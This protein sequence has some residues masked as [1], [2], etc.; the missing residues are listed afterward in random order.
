MKKSEELALI[1]Q[2]KNALYGR[3]EADLK[4]A[5]DDQAAEQF[6]EAEVVVD[7][8][9]DAIKTRSLSWPDR[10]NLAYACAYLLVTT[11]TMTEADYELLGRLNSPSVGVDM[12][13]IATHVLDMRARAEAGLKRLADEEMS[14]A[15][16]ETEGVIEAGDIPF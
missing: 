4:P 3:L 5:N 2:G 11:R 10:Q 12:L 8:Y 14:L 9:L 15:S 1:V 7:E 16:Q 13:G 6:M